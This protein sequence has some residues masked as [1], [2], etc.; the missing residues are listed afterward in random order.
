MS[1]QVFTAAVEDR[2]DDDEREGER[3]KDEDRAATSQKPSAGARR[4]TPSR[5]R[6]LF[7]V[8]CVGVARAQSARCRSVSVSHRR[9]VRGTPAVTYDRCENA[10]AILANHTETPSHAHSWRG[11]SPGSADGEPRAGGDHEHPSS[12]LALRR[13]GFESPKGPRERRAPLCAPAV[14]GSPPASPEPSMV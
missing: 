14:W 13:L 11:S 5:R 7:I 9:A 1:R 10:L 6:P 8:A 4:S 2:L 3:R 12:L